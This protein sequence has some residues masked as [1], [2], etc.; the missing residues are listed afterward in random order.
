VL[1]E[2]AALVHR[3]GGEFVSLYGRDVAAALAR[4]IGKTLNTEVVLGHRRRRW[5]PWDTTATLIRLLEDVDVHISGRT[6]PPPSRNRLRVRLR[7]RKAKRRF[8]RRAVFQCMLGVRLHNPRVIASPSPVPSPAS[9]G[10][11]T[12]RLK[13]RSR[14]AAGTPGP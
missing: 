2:Y 3:E 13:S 11:F 6:W 7:Q 4:Y 9:D 12:K 5:R 1:G 10:P 14:I 8:A